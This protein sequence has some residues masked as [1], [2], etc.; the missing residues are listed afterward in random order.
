MTPP[1]P[2]R[3]QASDGDRY[4]PTRVDDTN[5]WTTLR[6]AHDF[7]RTPTGGHTCGLKTDDTLWCWGDNRWGQLGNN[8]AYGPLLVETP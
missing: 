3:T 8:L 7:F 2:A 4:V 1:R 5:D 6:A